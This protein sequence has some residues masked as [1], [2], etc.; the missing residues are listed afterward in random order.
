ME[1]QVDFICQNC[2]YPRRVP[3]EEKG[4]LTFLEAIKNNSHCHTC[5]AVKHSYYYPLADSSEN[6]NKANFIIKRAF[7]SLDLKAL[8]V[9]SIL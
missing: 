9:R 2:R 5:S 6:N 7:K 1:K 3:L 4:I 8:L